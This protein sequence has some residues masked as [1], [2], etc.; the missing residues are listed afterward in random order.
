VW[1]HSHRGF[2]SHPLRLNHYKLNNLRHDGLGSLVGGYWL[3]SDTCSRS[4]ASRPDATDRGTGRADTTEEIRT[5]DETTRPILWP[6]AACLKSAYGRITKEDDDPRERGGSHYK[7]GADRAGSS[8]VH[9]NNL[10]RIN[11]LEVGRQ[12]SG[13]GL[14][15]PGSLSHSFAME[16]VVC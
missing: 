5:R 6:A 10:W 14:D 2:E 12:S 9:E 3:P 4:Q 13:S 8:H 1:C 15:S 7:F 16:A 11:V